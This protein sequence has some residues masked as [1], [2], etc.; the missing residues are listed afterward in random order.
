M[1]QLRE[2][3]QLEAAL[4][5]ADG[6]TVSIQRRVRG[7]SIREEGQIAEHYAERIVGEVCG[8]EGVPT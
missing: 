7:N 3:E 1:E 6:A 2:R 4:E 8:G 5:V